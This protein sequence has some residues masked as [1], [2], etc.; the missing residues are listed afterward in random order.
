[1][2]K[3]TKLRTAGHISKRTSDKMSLFLQNGG[4]LAACGG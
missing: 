2:G 1:M 4:M 3:L